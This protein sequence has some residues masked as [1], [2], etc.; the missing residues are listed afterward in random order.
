MRVVSRSLKPAPYET[1]VDDIELLA[2]RKMVP[3]RMLGR[4]PTAIDVTLA[5]ARLGGHLKHNGPPGW[6]TLGRGAE[7]LDTACRAWKAALKLTGQSPEF[8]L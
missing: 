7:K 5:I 2:L 8:E 4:K 1:V 3:K 6:L